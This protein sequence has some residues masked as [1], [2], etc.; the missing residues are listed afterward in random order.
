VQ[1]GGD[2]VNPDLKWVRKDG[3]YEYGPFLVGRDHTGLWAVYA[4]DDLAE[5]SPS[6]PRL[7]DAKEWVEDYWE[8]C[9]DQP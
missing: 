6:F 7:S 9:H 5:G 4:N 2:G 3:G 8:R 1:E